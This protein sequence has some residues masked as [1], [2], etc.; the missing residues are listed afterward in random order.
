[1]EKLSSL[2]D[3]RAYSVEEIAAHI[4]ALIR[5]QGQICPGLREAAC[6]APTLTLTQFLQGAKAAQI[7]EKSARRQFLCSRRFMALMD[8]VDDGK[9][10]QE[11]IDELDNW[12]WQQASTKQIERM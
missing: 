5:E 8:L 9:A 12:R 2:Y 11:Q 7:N 4:K 10:T 1:M 6:H 3:E